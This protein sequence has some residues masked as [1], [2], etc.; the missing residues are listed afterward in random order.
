MKFDSSKFYWVYLFLFFL[1][2]ALPL[3]NLPPWFS[4]PDWGKTI[5]FRII[6][7]ILLFF[8][9][10][11]KTRI[12]TDNKTLINTGKTDLRRYGLPFWL[13]IALLGIFFLATIFSLDPHFSFWGNPYRSGGFLNFAFYIIFAILSFLII[14]R[15]DWKKILN[16]A[17][18]IGIL[19]SVIA[20]FQQIGF[21]KGFF[22][23]FEYRPPSTM[24]GPIF[25]GIYLLLLVFL[26]VSLGIKEKTL[27]KKIFYFLSFFLFIFVIFLTYT[28]AVYFGLAIGFLY[29]LF[30]Y[31]KKLILLKIFFGIILFL[32]IYS[33]Y[34]INTQL[35]LP[36]FF[37]GII[38]ENKIL[39]GITQRLSISLA[40]EDPRISA[41]KVAVEAIKNRPI[42]G[43]G[44]ENFSIGFD[45]YYDPSLPYIEND[46]DN[47]WD[48]AH[49]FVFDI[50]TT[51]GIPALI[52][53]LALFGV[54]F[55][56]LQKLKHAE[57]H[58][59]EH[60][61]TQI[62]AHGIQAT[63]LAY[64]TADFFSFDTFST[65]LIL[66]LLISYS[67]FLIQSAS[68]PKGIA[69][70]YANEN[71]KQLKQK[72]TKNLYKSVFLFV[73][74][75]VLI[76][77]I[78]S[79]NL[80]PLRINKEINLAVY[81]SQNKD[82]ENALT[83][84]EGILPS[85]TYLNNYLRL[86]YIEVIDEC[87]K[88]KPEMTNVLAPKAVEALKENIKTTPYYTRNWISLGDYTNIL[89]EVGG[90]DLKNEANSYFQKAYELSPKRQEVFTRW[91]TTKLITGDY[92]GAKEKAQACIDLNPTL[93]D[94]WWLKGLS[95][96]Y[97]GENIKAGED[98]ETA[99]KNSYPIN[100]KEALVQL[101]KVYANLKNYNDLT[102][103]Y[104]ELINL[105]PS[106]VQYRASLA[107]IYK[108]MGE[109]EKARKE[110]LG[111][112]KIMPDAKE[113]VDK[114]LEELPQ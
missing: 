83:K 54:L 68:P 17:I 11:Q 112:L 97:L 57:S 35:G 43:Y 16:F 65:Y 85:K 72:D 37:Q 78:W 31:P 24:G 89:I 91:T 75:C 2:L 58:G 114:F 69:Q 93:G 48:R 105:E 29:F 76:W 26:T 101:A 49:N 34:S 110:A 61:K 88:E 90:Q 22:I 7:S 100:S 94:C 21:L 67:L 36:Q 84:M 13:L 80:K 38:Q 109:Y 27:I 30:F 74:F 47:W 73:L 95:E 15:G 50:G 77:F 33:L 14:R 52:V 71:K 28:R 56:Q 19:V 103:V 18:F 98:M 3:L 23:S 108:E 42:L 96:I 102:V 92:L 81:L 106:N 87:I 62:E 107:F 51:A 25:L 82:C 45:K 113:D 20:I 59:D 99:E 111:I 10:F 12:N 46:W 44:P 41:W 70:N 66:F 4:P 60:E 53:Y 86:K 32:G 104:K 39:L 55:W 79:F 1:I 40:I 6:L 5:V 64:L 9:I 63:F 8:F